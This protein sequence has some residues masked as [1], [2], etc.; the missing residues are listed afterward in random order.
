MVPNP[1]AGE[2]DRIEADN[3]AR[4]EIT[5]DCATKVVQLRIVMKDFDKS[6]QLEFP[7]MDSAIDH[8]RRL[9]SQ[10]TADSA[11]SD[12]SKSQTA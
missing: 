3:I 10:R 1:A 5:Q 2:A 8:Y 12:S 7:D 11:D 9:W 4:I 6:Y